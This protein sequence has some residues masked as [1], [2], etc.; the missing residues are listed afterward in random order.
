MSR[1]HRILLC[2]AA[3]L[4]IAA[5]AAE[6]KSS[7]LPTTPDGAD[8]VAQAVVVHSPGQAL[9]GLSQRELDL[10]GRGLQVFA[11]EF[12]PAMGLGPLFNST[13][14]IACHD[15]PAPGGYGDSTETHV[16]AYHPGASCDVLDANGGPVVQQHATP[17][18]QQALGIVTEP[19]PPGATASA[20][21]TT[22]LIFGL[23][24]LD[25][26]PERTIRALARLRYPEGVHGR[27]AV[28]A[29]GRVGRFGRKATTASL[30]EFNAGAFFNEMGITDAG[31][32]A[33]GTVAGQP[34]PAG[35]DL[36]RDPELDPASLGAVNAFVK[37]LGPVAP[38]SS[39]AQTRLGQQLFSEVRCPSCH[40]PFLMTGANPIPAL[41]F[42]WF[43]AYTDLLLHD[44]GKELADICNGVAGPSE[45]RTQPLI[46]MQF[47]D[48]FMHDGAS[49]TID[50]AIRRHGGEASAARDGYLGL[51][52]EQQAA[53]VAFVQGL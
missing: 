15:N 29:S 46:G 7:D 6:P 41:R 18:L 39:T 10:F 22:P 23:G 44:M 50:D 47:L 52:L 37:F 30:D 26:V 4:S 35:V 8:T 53:L 1:P 38:R 25:A 19:T 51:T 28:L 24:L 3:A 42:R 31:N 43:R 49:E 21:R 11:T 36:A 13:G 45:F 14:C 48:M 20:R 5:C 16:T 2:L 12:T 40:I 34:L 17:E 33:E 32:P 27:A 9:P